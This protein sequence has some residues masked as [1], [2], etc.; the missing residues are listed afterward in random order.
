FGPSARVRSVTVEVLKRATMRYEI[1]LAGAPLSRWRVIGKV[2][3]TGVAGESAC[4]AQRAL[5]EEGFNERPPLE[6]TVPRILGILPELELLLMEEAGGRSLQCLLNK[7][8]ARAEHVRRFAEV[9]VKL[10]R[11]PS[12]RVV[13][14]TVDQ[15]LAEKCRGLVDALAQ[16]FPDLAPP[17]ARIV[18]AAR[19]IEDDLL[20]AYPLS[21]GDYHP[22]QVHID[23]ER[24]WLLDL[25]RLR[26]RDPAYDV[27]MAVMKLKGLATK[28]GGERW[29]RELLR[30]FL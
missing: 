12:R 11:F 29:C 17:I 8:Q 26:R 23:S 28:R 10:H 20:P 13:P 14:F 4:A 7:R 21:H 22:G 6:I 18:A 2:F 30:E 16:D 24:C 15:H 25:D 19:E 1:E 9:L 5:W 3:A 27:A